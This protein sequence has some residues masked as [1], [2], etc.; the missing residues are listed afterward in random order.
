VVKRTT[1]TLVLLLAML[2]AAG[3]EP[4]FSLPRLGGAG[5]PDFKITLLDGKVAMLGGGP[6]YIVLDGSLW[7]GLGGWYLE[8][9]ADDGL[10]IGYAGPS[11]GWLFFPDS[12]VSFGAWLTAGMGGYVRTDP[13]TGDRSEGGF[14]VIEPEVCAFVAITPSSRIGIGASYRLGIPVEGT[15]ATL[16]Q[17]SGPSAFLALRY[18]AI[19]PIPPEERRQFSLAGGISQKFA[20]VN[21]Q[22]ARYDGGYTR[23]VIDH[24]WAIGAM[25][26]RVADG[27]EIDGNR[28]AAMEGGAWGERIFD[29]GGPFAVSV[30]CLAGVSMVGYVEAGTGDVV[31]APAVL[32]SPEV[33]ASLILTD[34]C[35]LSLG[36][37]LRGTFPVREVPGITWLD[38][39]GPTLSVDL[40]FGAY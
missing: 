25:G 21:G 11:A 35:R 37:A 18:G 26:Y 27:V 8:G 39:S 2:A 40:C 29:V 12:I 23:V 13:D 6:A 38:V 36:L 28:F 30:G 24:R 32:V 3:A 1:V 16:Q 7:L 19:R 17:L 9:D 5:G 22:V 20:M 14:I 4:L 33:K 10:F 31:G 34:F 15:A